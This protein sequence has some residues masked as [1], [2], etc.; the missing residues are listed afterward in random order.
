M[1]FEK[2]ISYHKA[3]A[4]YYESMIKV[5]EKNPIFKGEHIS[6]LASSLQYEAFKELKPIYY[7]ELRPVAKK[8]FKNNAIFVN[9]VALFKIL[10]LGRI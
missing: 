7:D 1:P 6:H 10:P 9:F 4:S 5:D 3:A 8:L 2:K